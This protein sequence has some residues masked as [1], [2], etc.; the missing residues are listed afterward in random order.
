MFKDERDFYREKID[1]KDKT[2]DSLL[3]S[4]RETNFLIRGLQDQI[5]R[6][7]TG[8]RQPP[9][10]QLMLGRQKAGWPTAD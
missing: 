8:R 5:P 10:G 1:R 3:E 6:L 2:I 4:D 7:G 9:I